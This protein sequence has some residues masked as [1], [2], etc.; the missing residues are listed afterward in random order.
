MLEAAPPATQLA[1]VPEEA[2]RLA[3]HRRR[4]SSFAA[5]ENV[6]W[7]SDAA[8]LAPIGP[9]EPVA[10]VGAEGMASVLAEAAA[11]T[12][13]PVARGRGWLGAVLVGTAGE[14]VYWKTDT[15]RHLGPCLDAF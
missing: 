7:N 8:G 2:A 11:L 13:R 14:S 5:C 12:G 6:L 4:K 1:A 9:V 10:L 15:V 3:S